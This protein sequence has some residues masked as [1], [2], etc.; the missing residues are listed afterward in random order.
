[1]SPLDRFLGFAKAGLGSYNWNK[2]SGN[3]VLGHRRVCAQL[4]YSNGNGLQGGIR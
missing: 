1:M 2:R 4:E 3:Y